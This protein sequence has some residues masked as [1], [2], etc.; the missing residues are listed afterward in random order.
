MK[1]LYYILA[2][3]AIVCVVITRDPKNLKDLKELYYRFLEI[4]P[5]KYETLKRG[6][7]I[8]GLAP[9]WKELGYNV[10]KGYEI[11]ICMDNNVNAMFHVLL[12]E[13]A[14]GTVEAYQ[15]NDEFWN[16]YNEL[17]DMAIQ[18]GLYTPT[19]EV[20]FCGKKISD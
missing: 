5:Q 11:C 16:N 2:I 20:K 17:R 9:F 10:N 15:H 4:L 1:Y 8:T 6:S 18:A 3:V 12:H 14:H 19:G 13:L 7:V